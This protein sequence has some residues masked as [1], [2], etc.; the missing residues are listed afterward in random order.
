MMINSIWK[1]QTRLS[2][3]EDDSDD[4]P[5]T[6]TIP[7]FLTSG[8]SYQPP[9]GLRVVEN[10]I[11]YYGDVT[12]DSCLELNRILVELDLKLRNTQNSLGS[13][14]L[15]PIIELHVNTNGGCIF[16]A[17]STV[18][19][20]RSLKSKVYTYNE[21]LVASAGTLITGIGHTR[22]IGQYSHMLI[23]QLSSEAY[24]K[25]SEIEDHFANVSHLMKCLKDFYKKHSKIPM[26]KL[27][28]LLKKDIFLNADECLLYGLVD[29]IK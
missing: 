7:I 17:F 12:S 21:G 10:K 11:F 19:T 4:T 16:S 3:T 1:R 28:D 27:D 29:V 25:F 2:T 15:T 20:I 13:D 22:F 5:N 6:G 14:V 24:G 9:T 18:D 23:H 8:E 26:K